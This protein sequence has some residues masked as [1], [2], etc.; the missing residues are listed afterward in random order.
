MKGCIN[1][2]VFG[3]MGFKIVF[4]SCFRICVPMYVVSVSYLLYLGMV[5]LKLVCERA[6][7]SWFKGKY[8]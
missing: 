1:Y 8:L 3:N 2:N 4:V 7:F 6:L 5:L